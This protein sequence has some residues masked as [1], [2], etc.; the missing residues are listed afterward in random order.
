[1]RWTVKT[2]AMF[3]EPQYKRGCGIA[4]C[5]RKANAFGICNK[6]LSNIRNRN[7][8]EN[9]PSVFERVCEL[10]D[11]DSP[12]AAECAELGK[13]WIWTGAVSTSG[14]AMLSCLRDYKQRVD[15]FLWSKRYGVIPSGHRLY[16]F[17]CKNNRCVNPEHCR[18]VTAR[19]MIL[20][21]KG[22]CAANARK[23]HC[24][25]GHEFTSDN[26]LN[27]G[28]RGRVCLKCVR[29]RRNISRRIHSALRGYKKSDATLKLVGCSLDGLRAHLE[30][31][32]KD[33][34]TWGN[35]G[36]YGWHIDHIKPCASFDLSDIEQ[37][38]KCFHFT[39][40]QPLWWYENVTQKAKGLSR[41]FVATSEPS[42]A[43]RLYA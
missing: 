4:G 19:Q 14:Y 42:V 18:P 26:I 33:G 2:R 21:G 6:H 1:M 43:V 22:A 37:Q 13:C 17:A 12:F 34:M 24:P 30:S 10:I 31:K 15:H 29:V 23:T 16:H 11:I 39:N 32:F 35:Y 20:N 5:S 28:R 8:T 3:S 7:T 25:H 41:S 9:R 36:R 40:L 38:K 27:G